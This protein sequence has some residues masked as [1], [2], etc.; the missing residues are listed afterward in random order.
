[1]SVEQDRLLVAGLRR[2]GLGEDRVEVLA[3]RL[4]VR[5]RTF[6]GQPPPRGDLGADPVA[7]SLLPEV[8]TPGPHGDDHLDRRAGRVE[9]HLAVSAERE[10][11]DVAAA[12]AVSANQ[13]VHRISQLFGRVGELH[14][15]ELR[16]LLEAL[17]VLAVP[18]DGRAPLRLVGADALEDAGAVVKPVLE[19]V[20]I[21]L[22]PW[23]EFAVHPDELCLLHHSLRRTI[24][25]GESMPYLRWSSAI[26]ASVISSVPAPSSSAP[27]RSAV[28]SP[29]SSTRSTAA[30]SA[31]A[32]SGL[33]R[34]WRNMSA[35]DRNVARGL[36]VPVPAMSGADPW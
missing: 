34:P 32:S 25:S 14:V 1:M 23:D 31:A 18:E 27:A 9:A 4:R 17:E 36:A 13:L 22:V 11:P 20:D 15:V 12:Q 35:T 19:H 26:T 29:F 6:G 10:R 33:S 8:G 5:D 28:R 21:G 2:L 7:L 30:S 24:S 3:G 16:R